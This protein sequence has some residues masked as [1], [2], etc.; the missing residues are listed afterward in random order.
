MLCGCKPASE[1]RGPGGLVWP[2]PV[3]EIQL[4]PGESQ[5]QIS[6]RLRNDGDK[7]E[8]IESVSSDCGCLLGDS[9]GLEIA[10]GAEA[11]LPM[12]FRANAMMSGT[13]VEKTVKVRVRGHE[14]HAAL[15]FRAHVPDTIRITP[16]RLEWKSGDLAWQEITI[17]SPLEYELLQTRASNTGF[18]WETLPRDGNKQPLKLK[19]RPLDATS[20]MSLLT[21]ETSLPDPWGKVSVSL[22]VSANPK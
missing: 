15:A 17:E 1:T 13:T 5:Q 9:S 18:Q 4:K 6:F 12:T 7:P 3:V 16:S 19:V 20:K 10:P 2:E 21:L 22:A 11:S 8:I 14:S